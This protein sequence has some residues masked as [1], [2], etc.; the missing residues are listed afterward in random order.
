MTA[1]MPHVKRIKIAIETKTLGSTNPA[2]INESGTIVDRRINLSNM[3][4][5]IVLS[6]RRLLG[7]RGKINLL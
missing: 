4:M 3:I 5:Q 1:V 7:S 2:D 6:V